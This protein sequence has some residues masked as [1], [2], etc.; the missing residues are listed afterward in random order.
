MKIPKI[1]FL[2]LTV[3]GFYTFSVVNVSAAEI[4]DEISMDYAIEQASPDDIDLSSENGT[5][6][7]DEYL[8]ELVESYARVKAVVDS[9][10]KTRSG[11]CWMDRTLNVNTYQQENGYYC[12][13]ANI[14]QVVQYINGSSASQATYASR[15]GTNSSVGT[16]VYKMR[17]ELNYRQ[18]YNHYVYQQMNSGSYDTFMTIVQG[19]IFYGN[20]TEVKGKPVILHAKTASLYQYNGTNLGHYLTVNGYDMIGGKITYVD[21]WNANYGRGTTLGQHIDSAINV[22]NTVSG[23]RYVIY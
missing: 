11:I 18:S 2:S 1:I 22:F 5:I 20:D 14:K 17:D 10:C 16:L 4:D 7:T 8:N 15:M 12:G 13:P 21:P 3:F 9:N 19:N 23:S 6:Y